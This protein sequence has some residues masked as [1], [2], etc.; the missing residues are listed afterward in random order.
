MNKDTRGK[1]KTSK[2]KYVWIAF[3]CSVIVP[4]AGQFYNGHYGRCT[5]FLVLFLIGFPF[6]LDVNFVVRYGGWL[7]SIIEATVSAYRTNY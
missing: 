5:I 6:H 3:T 7:C 2:Q 1:D 4:R